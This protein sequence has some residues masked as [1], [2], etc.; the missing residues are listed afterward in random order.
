MAVPVTTFPCIISHQWIFTSGNKKKIE[1][2][3]VY[4]VLSTVRG[5]EKP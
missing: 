1:K 2:I 5:S 3:S 4:L